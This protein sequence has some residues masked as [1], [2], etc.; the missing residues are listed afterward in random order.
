MGNSD[1]SGS[2]EWRLCHQNYKRSQIVYMLQ[3]TL[4]YI[5]VIASIVNLAVG[6]QHQSIW[7]A[8]LG[9]S[10]GVLLPSPTLKRD[11]SAKPVL[12]NNPV[13]HQA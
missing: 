5:I 6:S 4:V 1:G 12:H 13:V 9:A 2:T 8:L 3:V 11:D 7:I 10:T